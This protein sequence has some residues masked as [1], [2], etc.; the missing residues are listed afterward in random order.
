MKNA[1]SHGLSQQLMRT[2]RSSLIRLSSLGGWR[3]GNLLLPA[4]CRLGRLRLGNRLWP[5]RSGTG[6]V[7]SEMFSRESQ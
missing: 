1:M 3:W 4:R 2:F 6:G 7:Q 5:S